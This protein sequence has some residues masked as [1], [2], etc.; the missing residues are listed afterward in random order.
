MLIWTIVFVSHV[1]NEAKLADHK[2]E[3]VVRNI[4]T[5]T[6]S[7]HEFETVSISL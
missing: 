2:R 3:T 1:I 5:D 4:K 6:R 7:K